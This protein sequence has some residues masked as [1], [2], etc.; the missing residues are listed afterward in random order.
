MLAYEPGESVKQDGLT[1]KHEDHVQAK[2][3]SEKKNVSKHDV[4]KPG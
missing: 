1:A 2:A 3:I 4:P